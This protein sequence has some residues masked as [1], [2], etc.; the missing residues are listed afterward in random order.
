MM[1]TYNIDELR[2]EL[3]VETEQYKEMYNLKIRA[4][5]LAIKQINKH[6]D[7]TVKYEQ[8]KIG[9]TITAILFTFKQKKAPKQIASAD[10]FI[11]M[12]D[13]HISTFGAKLASSSELGSNAPIG[14]SVDD[15]A[16]IVNELKDADQQ[17]KY[18]K[19]LAKLDF[20]VA[21]SKG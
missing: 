19:H 15:F 7:I 4:I 6:K 9:R 20:K 16:K 8:H 3:G 10:S 12:T 21:K 2:Q 11:K 14:G 18:I 13:E 17:N 5:D 1:Q